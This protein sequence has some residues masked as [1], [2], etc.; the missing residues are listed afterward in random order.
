[1]PPP[2][3]G[4]PSVTPTLRR[5]REQPLAKNRRAAILTEA[6]AGCRNLVIG[7]ERLLPAERQAGLVELAPAV[8][9]DNGSS[10]VSR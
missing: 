6:Y 10:S 3:T 2:H 5:H 8:V 1:M 4:S 7:I 9:D